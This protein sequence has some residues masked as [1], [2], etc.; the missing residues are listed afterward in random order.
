[1]PGDLHT[2]TTFSDGSEP[3]FRLPLPA[4][5]TGLT[6]LAITD[7]DSM[8][9]IC[10]AKKHPVMSGVSLIP[11]AEFS[12][13]DPATGRRVHLLGYWPQICPALEAHCN[14]IKERRNAVHL[15]SAREIEKIYPQFC[16]ED[17]LAYAQDSGILYKSCI[18]QVLQ[19]LGIADTIYGATYQRLFGKDGLVVHEPEYDTVDTVLAMLQESKAVV[20]FAHPSVYQSMDLVRRLAAEGRI[21][22]IE[23]DHPRN[24]AEDKA[25]C[26]ALCE[27]Y[28]LIH[29]GGTDFHGRNSKHPHPIGTCTTTDEQIERIRQLALQRQSLCIEK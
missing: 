4:S 3:V 16:T 18:M 2:H 13:V 1:M 12:A 22:G 27:T 7:H 26:A 17:A 11:A 29:T 28:G 10:Y 21:D 15:Q 23:V 5:R 9:S 19:N 25:E 14:R 20:V 8:N 24:S 6:H